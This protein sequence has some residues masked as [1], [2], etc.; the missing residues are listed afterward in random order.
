MGGKL[1]SLSKNRKVRF[2]ALGVCLFVIGMIIYFPNYAKLKKLRQENRR[3]TQDNQKLQEEIKDFEDKLE[4]LGRDPF[5]Y[6]KIA[7]ED[8]GVAKENEIVIDIEE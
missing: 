5:V 1:L 7:R 8:L 2:L 4:K 6:E 3:I